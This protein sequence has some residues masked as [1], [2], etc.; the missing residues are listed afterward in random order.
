[1][2]GPVLEVDGLRTEFRIGGLR[3]AAVDGIF[4]TLARGET[5]ALVGE[6]GCGKSM[7]AAVGHLARCHVATGAMVDA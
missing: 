7:P 1:V 6:S 2:S 4:L 3:H 5:L